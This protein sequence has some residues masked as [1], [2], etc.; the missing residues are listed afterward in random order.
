MSQN[1]Q[2][3]FNDWEVA[4]AK[5]LVYEY[6][7]K[8]VCLSKEDFDD[9]L[10]EC[11]THWFFSKDCYE[12]EKGASQKTF[13]GKIIRNK[14]TDIVREREADKRKISR[15]TVSLDGVSGNNEDSPVL[16]EK[17]ES[18]GFTDP[19]YDPLVDIQLKIDIPKALKKLT[20]QQKKLCG[21]L[22]EKGLNV[23]EASKYL[24]TPR[25]TVYD[26][27]SRIRKI[28]EK[29]GLKDYLK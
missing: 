2:G 29:E 18:N 1:Y 27:L 14:L 11:L 24:K 6:Q 19:Q 7:R 26:E 10:Q 25:S 21:L 16:C 9:L 23:K 28:F 15:F 4:V 22:G 13:M 5:K 8:W 20:L 3:L 17:I 12:A